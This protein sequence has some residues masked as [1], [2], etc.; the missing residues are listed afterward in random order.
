MDFMT[1]MRISNSGLTA[2]RSWMAVTAANLANAHTTRTASGEP[3]RR[4]TVIYESVPVEDRFD[5]SLDAAMGEEVDAVKVDGVVAD[6]RD[7]IE[8]YDPDHPDADKRGIVRLPN[9][10]TAEEM[11]NLVMASRTYQANIA[12]LNVAKRLAMKAM[13]IGK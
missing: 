8:V 7:F 9:I 1:A 13:E 4:R 6:Q 5:A 2:S 3:Y 11:A 12:A 10:N